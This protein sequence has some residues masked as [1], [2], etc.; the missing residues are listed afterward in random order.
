MGLAWYRLS[1]ALL[2]FRV[3]L[4]AFQGRLRR[5]GDGV[6]GGEA[7]LL[8]SPGGIPPALRSSRRIP[9]P[10]FIVATA[11]GRR[12]L[13]FWARSPLGVTVFACAKK[14]TKKSTPCSCAVTFGAGPRL[15]VCARGRGEA[16]SC[17]RA[18][19][20]AIP[21]PL[22]PARTPPPGALARGP[23]R[24]K[25]HQKQQKKR[26]KFPSPLEGEGAPKG[27]ERGA[28]RDQWQQR[29]SSARAR[30]F[31]LSSPDSQLSPRV[32]PG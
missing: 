7:A 3:P 6:Q 8:S 31:P 28:V 25:Q 5:S 10:G 14:V 20:R 30:C 21:G 18:P 17:R 1:N 19:Q 23:A 22:P 12:F 13:K 4:K 11:L 2:L 27:R 16:T 26:R 29:F 9:N 15:G 32:V 24:Q